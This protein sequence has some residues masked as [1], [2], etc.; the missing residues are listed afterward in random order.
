MGCV[1]HGGVRIPAGTIDAILRHARAAAPMECCG[2]LI[3]DRE[4]IA[5]ALP[6]HNIADQ[7]ESRFLV[8]PLDHFNA[9]RSAR[10]RGLDVVG[11]YHSHP[12]SDACASPTDLAEASYPNH[13]FLI[14][15]LGPN[16][17]EVRLYRFT[18]GNFHATPFVTVP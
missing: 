17:A 5:D 4:Q 9:L 10:A 11:F 7:P 14:A 16:P 12:R 13:F 6:A 1:G 15:G 8:D 2:V 3:G 18:E